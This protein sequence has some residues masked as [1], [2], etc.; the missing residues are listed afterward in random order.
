MK[1]IYNYLYYLQRFY[2]HL[3]QVIDIGKTHENRPMLIVKIGTKSISSKPT[4]FIEGG[5]M[6]LHCVKFVMVVKLTAQFITLC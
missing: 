1:D 3:V 4:I 6:L 5:N 2:P